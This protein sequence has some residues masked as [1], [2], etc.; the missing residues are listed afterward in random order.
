MPSDDNPLPP[1][2]A[3]EKF[4]VSLNGFESEEA[5]KSFG[6]LLIGGINA[7][8]RYLD[9]E[10]L[11]GVT[12]A[13]DYCAA[14]ANLDR[15]D[16]S[17]RHPTPTEHYGVGVAMSVPVVREGQILS[18]IVLSTDGILPLQ[19]PEAPAYGDAL[20]LL[21]HECAHVHDLKYWELCFPSTML[22][23]VKGA[24]KGYL[25]QVS[26]ACWSEYSASRR[27]AR[28][29]PDTP[30]AHEEGLIETL[31]DVRSNANKCIIEYRSH[32]DHRRVF[33]EMLLHYGMLLK[34]TAYLAG[35]LDGLEQTLE[36]RSN[37]SKA[38]AEHAWA[39]PYLSRL[40]DV[41][42][43]LWDQYGAWKS[44]APF[45]QI[46]EIARELIASCGVQVRSIDDE[47]LY[48]DVPFTPETVDE[49]DTTDALMQLTELGRY[50]AKLKGQNG[51][52]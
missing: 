6:Y 10:K 14:L 5:A 18:H 44:F 39:A 12:V 13:A 31:N 37:I 48:I 34:H 8:S 4:G 41:L 28:F 40:L 43:E 3:P 52:D 23:P 47:N 38:V 22:S 27:S 19:N 49:S 7:L 30:S 24:L 42:R 46:G 1:A 15:G 26:E 21:A 50:F 16:K 35:H 32:R 36:S 25:W 2:T 33:E 11:D 17:L 51:A 9:L 29:H 45:E 20:Y